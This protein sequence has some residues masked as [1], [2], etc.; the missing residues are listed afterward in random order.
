MLRSR[1]Y[2]VLLVRVPV[3]ALLLV[4]IEGG[5]VLK[6]DIKV[7]H[8]ATPEQILSK[9]S[10]W[11]I[12]LITTELV[13]NWL[14]TLLI[15]WKLW[16]VGNKVEEADTRTKNMYMHVI[17]ALVES[18]ML[19]SITIGAFV[20]ITVT[21]NVSTLPRRLRTG[22]VDD[23]IFSSDAHKYRHGLWAAKDRWDCTS[24]NHSSGS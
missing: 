8:H 16:R 18:G 24:P 14:V 21:G 1:D 13:A 5:F 11:T 6:Y 17:I 20:A 12:A 19:F 3:L 10:A 4:C 7:L 22:K 2:R 9:Y 15:I 23:L